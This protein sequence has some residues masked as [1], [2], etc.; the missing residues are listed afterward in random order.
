[1][2]RV[3]APEPYPVAQPTPTSSATSGHNPALILFGIGGLM[4]AIGGFLPRAELSVGPIG[5]VQTKGV[6]IGLVLIGALMVFRAFQV[7]SRSSGSGGAAILFVGPAVAFGLLIYEFATAKSDLSNWATTTGA[8]QLATQFHVPVSEVSSRI[9]A[10]LSSGQTHVTYKA[11][12]YVALIGAVLSLVAAIW[13]W[14]TGRGAQQVPAG[15]GW[16]TPAPASPGVPLAPNSPAP[17]AP[18]APP[19]SDWTAPPAGWTA[20]STSTPSPPTST[21]S[22]PTAQPATP[23]P[24]AQPPEEPESFPPPPPAQSG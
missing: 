19:P 13:A 1:M 17:G 16:A 14:M 5:V 2:D 6:A 20:P 9:Q 12:L 8:Q 7:Y 24:P 3:P 21:P 11:G 23:P 4:V 10:L 15:P 22:P 18:A